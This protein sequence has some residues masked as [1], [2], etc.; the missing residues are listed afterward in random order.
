MFRVNALSIALLL[1]LIC[2]FEALEARKVLKMDK[3][4]VYFHGG[5]LILSSLPRGS[6]P[7]S[8]PSKGGDANIVGDIPFASPMDGHNL[9]SVP[10]PD[11]GH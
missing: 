7:P 4:K 6:V 9:A 10:A 2:S 8:S 1:V 3:N 11:V 5:S